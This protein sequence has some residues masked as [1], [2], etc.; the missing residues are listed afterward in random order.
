MVP[1]ATCRHVSSLERGD[2]ARFSKGPRT[3]ES[4]AFAADP[5]KLASLLLRYLLQYAPWDAALA[6]R[7]PRPWSS[8]N[9]AIRG[10]FLDRNEVA[11]STQ[12]A[13][14]S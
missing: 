5:S 14:G 4:V 7:A 12:E 10:P 9:L 8:T 11:L 2:A 13:G 6:V 1:P 3:A